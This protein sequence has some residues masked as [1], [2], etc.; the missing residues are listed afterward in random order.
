MSDSE[1]QQPEE[2]PGSEIVAGSQETVLGAMQVLLAARV[3][4][5]VVGRPRHRQRPRP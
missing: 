1:Q 3:P 4:V 2:Q 5:L